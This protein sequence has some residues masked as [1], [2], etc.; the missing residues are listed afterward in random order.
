MTYIKEHDMSYIIECTTDAYN[1]LFKH[2]TTASTR[3]D[4]I[5]ADTLDEARKMMCNWLRA[6]VSD[7]GDYDVESLCA[8][9][10]KLEEGDTMSASELDGFAHNYTLRISAFTM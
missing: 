10:M 1:A 8:I 7:E 9:A 6:N 2:W 4:G 3:D 5:F